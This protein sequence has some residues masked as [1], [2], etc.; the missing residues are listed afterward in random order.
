MSNLDSGREIEYATA[1][2]GHG[3]AITPIEM[4]TALSSLANGGNIIKPYIVDEIKIK[5]NRNIKIQPEIL[6]RVLKEETSEEISR[7]LSEVF[8]EALL[9]G[10]VKIDRYSIA[11]KT[12]TAELLGEDGEYEEGRY[13]HSFFGYFPAFDAKFL[14]FLY[15][16]D[17][18]K[19]QYASGTLTAPFMNIVKFLINYYEIQPDS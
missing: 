11:A 10:T 16:I 12:G 17:P 9:G 3:I 6:R 15:V 2:F 14:I 19:D 13:F 18:L 7:M 5:N 4:A 8:D 1:S